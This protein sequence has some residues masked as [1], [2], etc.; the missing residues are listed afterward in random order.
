MPICDNNVDSE[1]SASVSS[2]VVGGLGEERG[3]GRVVICA[4]NEGGKG[5]AT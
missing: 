1:D 5:T 3:D 4:T 2:F